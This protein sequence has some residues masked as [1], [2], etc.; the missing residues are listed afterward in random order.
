LPTAQYVPATTPGGRPTTV[1]GT[2][3]VLVVGK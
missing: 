2:F 1:P 3:Q